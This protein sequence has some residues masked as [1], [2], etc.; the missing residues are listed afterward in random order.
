[1]STAQLAALRKRAI[2]CLLHNAEH[3][4]TAAF[5]FWS[6]YAMALRNLERGKGQ[7]M[8]E[9][10]ARSP[11]GY[12]PPA[13]LQAAWAALPEDAE[14]LTIDQVQQFLTAQGVQLT[15]DPIAH[16]HF[17]GGQQLKG[18]EVAAVDLNDEH[19]PA[20]V[21]GNDG[22]SLHAASCKAAIVT[23]EGGAA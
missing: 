8:A 22:S 1:M 17:V 4:D 5:M 19:A 11:S 16:G 3:N 2:V 20:G 23:R 15:R 9:K 10:D 13:H 18:S 12:E 21:D 7:A 14:Q 6:G